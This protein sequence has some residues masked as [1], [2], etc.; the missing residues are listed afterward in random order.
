VRDRKEEKTM[1]ANDSVELYRR[2]R[3][4]RDRLMGAWLARATAAVART[5]RRACAGAIAR[6]RRRPA[7]AAEA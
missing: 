5:A 1:V 4:E 2:A 7:E 3:R 6:W